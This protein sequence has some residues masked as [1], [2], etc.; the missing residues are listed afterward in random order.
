MRRTA[1]DARTVGESILF[2]FG[3]L[4]FEHARPGTGVV[5][6]T[7]RALPEFGEEPSLSFSSFHPWR[8]SKSWI[9]SPFAD[10]SQLS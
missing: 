10:G 9:R 6:A 1:P 2:A 8:E 3:S 5:C 7:L 4:V